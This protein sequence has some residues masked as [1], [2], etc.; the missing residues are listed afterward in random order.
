MPI[1]SAL[2]ETNIPGLGTPTRG[3]VRDVYDMGDL[4]VLVATDRIST[5]DCV[6]D[7]CVPGKGHALTQSATEGFKLINTPSHF[8][9]S[10]DPNVMVVR[11]ARVYPVEAVV[12]RVLTGSG[13]RSYEATGEVCGIKLPKYLRKNH[14]LDEPIFTPTTKASTGHDK[15]ITFDEMADSIGREL[16]CRIRDSSLRVFKIGY[17]TVRRN[18]GVLADT[19][20]EL[21]DIPGLGLVFA[22]EIFT[23]DSS[24]FIEANEYENAFN[25]G[26][27]PKWLDKQ[28]VRDYAESQG[29]KGE[30]KPPHLP[31][32][33]IEKD[34]AAL[35]GAYRFLT[36][37]EL[38]PPAEPLS[39]ERIVRNLKSAGIIK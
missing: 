26:R 30:G 14:M 20:F 32:E 7:Q 23:H 8:I 5:H 3:K 10:P 34:M 24:R 38:S 33:I 18:G 12:R 35:G 16:A 9:S 22:D 15:P 29:F 31:D 28:V 21:A 2:R 39:E 6:Y 19:K 37:R 36:G 1:Y 17:D 25:E 27:D 13:W 4:L 11:K